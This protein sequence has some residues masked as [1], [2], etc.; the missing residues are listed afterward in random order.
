[1][2]LESKQLL[3]ATGDGEIN[4]HTNPTGRNTALLFFLFFFF[5]T[6]DFIVCGKHD[7]SVS[8]NITPCPLIIKLL[9]KIDFDHHRSV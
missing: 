8:L 5:L 4:V 9:I 7:Y 2:V 6:L 1:M 3:D